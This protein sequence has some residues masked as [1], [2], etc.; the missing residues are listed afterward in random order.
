MLGSLRRTVAAQGGEHHAHLP[1]TDSIT[2]WDPRERRWAD[3]GGA[4]SEP[5]LTARA[6]AKTKTNL[7]IAAVRIGS[8]HACNYTCSS[9][10]GTLGAVPH[11][12][13]A[14]KGA[15]WSACEGGGAREWRRAVDVDRAW[16]R[17]S[18]CHSEVRASCV[19]RWRECADCLAV[20][21]MA[22]RDLVCCEGA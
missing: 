18:T 2:D 3:G 6:S 11:E 10:D 21:G 13:E 9:D 1:G 7:A 8:W 17:P 15:H 20:R 12:R 22:R 4:Q 19:F 5:R 14:R 16:M